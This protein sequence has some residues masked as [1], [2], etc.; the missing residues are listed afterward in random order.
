MELLLSL[1][2]VFF[3]GLVLGR[4]A[5]KMGLPSLVGYLITGILLGYSGFGLL[6]EELLSISG[7][8]RQIA[9]LMILLKAGLTLQWERLKKVGKPALFLA[10]CPAS[11]EILSCI[12]M[13][14]LFFDLG[15]W[16]A[17]LLGT[18]LAAV[19]PAVVVPRMVRFLERGIGAK[20][21]APE[22][23]LAGASLDDVFVIVL[24]TSLLPLAQGG[25]FSLKPLLEL[26][27]SLVLAVVLGVLLGKFLSK[28]SFYQE[29]G[30]E[31]K[32]LLLLA[33]SFGLLALE[34]F[35]PLSA[36]LT[37]MIFAMCLEQDAALSADFTSLWKG[38]EVLL[39]V[40]VGAEVSLAYG[41]S[42]GGFALIVLLIG[43]VFRGIGVALAVSVA[44]LSK[45]EKI[46]VCISYL[47]KATVQAGI[48]GIPLAMGMAC[49]ELVLTFAVLSIFVTAPL[50][51]WL[52]DRYGEGLLTE[53]A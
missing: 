20:G 8:L 53:G 12:V 14:P 37:V 47:P 29:S 31:H 17:A 41:L 22:I 23:V 35:V 42:A 48:G 38:A 28:W 2:L 52:I 7:E 36:L 19:S 6:S 15:F 4:V 51:A 45:K 26:P 24:F 11:L 9:L 3:F 5:E 10:F 50:G 21:Q 34:E 13:A 39:F 16:E 43:L 49:G 32:V 30:R 1:S 27:I 33:L 25:E 40:L 44:K 46:F 18:V